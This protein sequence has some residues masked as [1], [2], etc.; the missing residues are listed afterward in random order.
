MIETKRI[1]KLMIDRIVKDL[2]TEI[3]F[4][5]EPDKSKIV[6]VLEI[7]KTIGMEE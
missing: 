3:F 4:H 7:L 5:D 1:N 2:E 6:E